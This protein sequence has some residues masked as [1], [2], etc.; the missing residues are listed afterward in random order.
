MTNH[1]SLPL[2]WFKVWWKWKKG[3][4]TDC[5]DWVG[6]FHHCGNDSEIMIRELYNEDNKKSRDFRITGEFKYGSR[7]R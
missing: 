5:K 1:K 3:F 6:P 7:Q 2:K 4:D